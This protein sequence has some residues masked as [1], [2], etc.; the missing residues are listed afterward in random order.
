M[1]RKQAL[2]AQQLRQSCRAEEYAPLLTQRAYL[3]G[4]ADA[5]TLTPRELRERA[6]QAE[7]SLRLLDDLLGTARLQ[8]VA[9]A[10]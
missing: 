3:R 4:V 10:I 5:A 7:R 9:G 1:K 8:G 6:E 2:R